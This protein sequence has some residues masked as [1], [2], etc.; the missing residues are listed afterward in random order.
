M[1]KLI[2]LTGT[3][4]VMFLVVFYVMFFLTN[5]PAQIGDGTTFGC[6]VVPVGVTAVLLFRAVLKNKGG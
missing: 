4:V 3:V 6:V 1:K 5:F 2:I